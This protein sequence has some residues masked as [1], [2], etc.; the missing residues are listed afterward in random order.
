MTTDQEAPAFTARRLI[1]SVDRATLATALADGRDPAAGTWPYASLVLVAADLDASPLLLISSIAEHTKNL[2]R[3]ARASLLFDGTHGLDD[4]LTGARVTVLGELR[5]DPD[6]A[7]LRR[8]IARHPAAA[9]Y[10]GF[11]DFAVYRLAI[12]RAHLVAGF[13]RIHWIDATALID[14]VDAAPWLR[15]AETGILEHMNRDHAATLD[16]YAQHLLGREGSGWRLTGV[17]RAGA[18]LRRGG[19]VAR[20]DFPRPVDDLDAVRQSFIALA[21]SAKRGAAPP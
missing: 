13:G 2:V 16:L 9:L 7:R 15:D 11:H 21:Q 1:R 19:A 3:D 17:D 5:T 10:G 20:L 14:P 12:T 18:D 8:F 6:P 4:P